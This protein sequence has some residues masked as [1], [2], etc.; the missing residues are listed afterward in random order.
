MHPHFA[1]NCLVTVVYFRIFGNC[2]CCR[3]SMLGTLCYGFIV[4]TQELYLCLLGKINGN[5]QCCLIDTYSNLEGRNKYHRQ[6]VCRWIQILTCLK[7]IFSF[8]VFLFSCIEPLQNVL[9]WF[10]YCYHTVT[11]TVHSYSSVASIVTRLVTILVFF[12]FYFA[13][14]YTIYFSFK[15][16]YS[17]KIIEKNTKQ[18]DG[19]DPNLT[20]LLL[21]IP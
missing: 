3:N 15:W 16:K 13:V 8:F 10:L 20:I 5:T 7:I 4:W 11:W 17:C 12:G 21:N 1:E 6:T 9:H 2:C 14:K 18:C 19:N